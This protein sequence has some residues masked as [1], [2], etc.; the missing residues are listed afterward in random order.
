[1][2]QPDHIKVA[3]DRKRFR[4]YVYSIPE[5]F[6]R[7]LTGLSSGAARELSHVI[8]PA[9]V[10]RSRLY[11]SLV[12]WTLGFL[13]DRSRRSKEPRNRMQGL[14]LPTFSFIVRLA[15]SGTRGYCTRS[16]LLQCGCLQ[17][18]PISRV[19]GASS[20]L[21]WRKPCRKGL[22]ERGREFQAVDQLLE[23][24]ERQRVD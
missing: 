2:G 12:G 20:S 17:P 23:G 24:L 19:P 1:M 15:R 16:T 13:I 14:F 3:M 11:Q 9:R 7:S 22:L 21:R 4:G 18:W 6:L 10:R 8:L 5:R